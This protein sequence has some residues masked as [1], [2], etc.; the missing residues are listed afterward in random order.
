MSDKWLVVD[1]LREGSN[2]VRCIFSSG[3]EREW[4]L[5]LILD[6]QRV[7]QESESSQTRIVRS[8]EMQKR[9]GSVKKERSNGSGNSGFI[10]SGVAVIILSLVQCG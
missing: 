2:E 8:V 5:E 9:S 10:G 7:P 4:T 6:L 1:D 3:P